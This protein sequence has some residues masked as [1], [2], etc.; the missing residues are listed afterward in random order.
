M[1]RPQFLSAWS[2]A[3]LRRDNGKPGEMFQPAAL[4]NNQVETNQS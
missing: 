3:A 4:D 2:S 1:P